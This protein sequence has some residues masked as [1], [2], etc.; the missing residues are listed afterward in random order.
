MT[1]VY[2]HND[3][4]SIYPHIGDRKSLLCHYDVIFKPK[5]LKFCTRT[6]HMI[7][8]AHT[9]FGLVRIQGSEVKRGGGI[10]PPSSNVLYPRALFAKSA[11]GCL[12]HHYSYPSAQFVENNTLD[13]FVENYT[14]GHLVWVNTGG[15]RA[16]FT[17]R[18]YQSNF[19]RPGY[20][21][22]FHKPGVPEHF[23]HILI[24]LHG[25]SKHL[26]Q[27]KLARSKRSFSEVLTTC[28][29][30][31]GWKMRCELRNSGLAGRVVLATMA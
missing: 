27:R 6:C 30:S 4:T 20:Q 2:R 19:H 31:R 10:R 7:V 24:P 22:N 3:K 13:Q 16:I 17:D 9:E 25:V 29:M 18:G 5:R 26:R 15:T 1:S 14:P 11:T 28:K 12:V 8:F 21:S 23:F